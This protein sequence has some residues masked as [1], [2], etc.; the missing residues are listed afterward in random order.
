MASPDSGR[1]RRGRAPSTR[2]PGRA[3]CGQPRSAGLDLLVRDDLA[4]L[5][6]VG[7][8]DD[9]LDLTLV[10]ELDLLGDALAVVVVHPGEERLTIRVALVDAL[11]ED[12]RRVVG[13]SGVGRRRG[14]ERR[15]EGVEE[16][17]L[18]LG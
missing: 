17:L 9:V 11:Q 1:G 12:V 2:V 3:R 14:V 6:L 4:V 18:L 13:L 8:D 5:D 15:L 16:V 7:P 10:V